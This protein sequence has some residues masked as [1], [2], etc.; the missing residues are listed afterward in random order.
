MPELRIGVIQLGIEE[1]QRKKSREAMRAR[2]STL[3]NHDKVSCLYNHNQNSLLEEYLKVGV[4][5]LP[6][7]L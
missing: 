1:R 7:A 6:L 2:H 5:L 4:L 3:V